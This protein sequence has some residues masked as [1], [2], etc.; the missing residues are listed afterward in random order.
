MRI[1]VDYGLCESNGVCMGIDPE[2]LELGDD[3]NLTVLKPEVGAERV[4]A[5]RE[6]VRRCPRQ[7]I[8]LEEST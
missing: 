8:S 7:A 4:A 1:H 5:M 6:A 3:D 2:V